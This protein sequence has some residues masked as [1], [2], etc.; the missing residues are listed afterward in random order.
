MR[1]WWQCRWGHHS[2]HVEYDVSLPLTLS[3][4]V[5]KTELASPHGWL[6]L[7]VIGADGTPE[8]WKVVIPCLITLQQQGYMVWMSILERR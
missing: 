6:H 2:L 8:G 3:G 7:D 5:T 4:T 1:S